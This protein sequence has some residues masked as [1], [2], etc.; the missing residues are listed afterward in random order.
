MRVRL[1]Y[2]TDGLE[3]TL[4]DDRVTVIEPVP[5]P[6]VPDARETLARA[7]AAPIGASPLRQQVRPDQRIAISVCRRSSRRCRMFARRM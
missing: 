5:R 3:V 6:A 2:G 4:P 1:D 7:I